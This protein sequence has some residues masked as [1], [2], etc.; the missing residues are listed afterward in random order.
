M[1]LPADPR[2]SHWRSPSAANLMAKNVPLARLRSTT[3]PSPYDLL[4][5][6]AA[7]LFLSVWA[8]E[9]QDPAR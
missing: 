7:M 1:P 5:L 3:V 6:L 9:A 8:T 4:D 2:F